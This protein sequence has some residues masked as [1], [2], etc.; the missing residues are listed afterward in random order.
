MMVTH[1][2]Y[3]SSPQ[4]SLQKLETWKPLTKKQCLDLYTGHFFH[5]TEDLSYFIRIDTV[6]L[7]HRFLKEE[8]YSK[9]MRILGITM[10]KKIN[11]QVHFF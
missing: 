7:L 4:Q 2:L 5:D 9:K 10:Q 3:F 11:K 6:N 1:T 8:K